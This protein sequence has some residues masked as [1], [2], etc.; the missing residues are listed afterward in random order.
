MNTTTFTT[1]LQAFISATSTQRD[2]LEVLILAGLAQVI[3]SGNTVYLTAVMDACTGVRSLPTNKVKAYILGH[4][5]NLK[6]G[7]NKDGN[8]VFSKAVKGTD[9]EVTAPTSDERWY[10]VEKESKAAPAFDVEAKIKAMV[11]TMNKAAKD[12]LISEEQMA[13]AGQLCAQ[14]NA[15]VPVIEVA[16]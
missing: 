13:L 11:K 2:Q 12:G 16:K 15:L 8:F 7:K 9:I 14:L 10:L 1:A 6:Y 4:T 5:T 3:E